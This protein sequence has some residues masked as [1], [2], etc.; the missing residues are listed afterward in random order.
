MKL[1]P[2]LRLGPFSSGAA[3]SL[4][5]MSG[6]LDP[7]ITFARASTATF[8]G[9]DGLIQSAAIDTPRF[10]YDPVT[11]AAKGLLIE[12]ARTNLL[13]Y[14]EQFDNAA[15]T[16]AEAT[17]S[18]NSSAAPDGTNT[19]DK[20]IPNVATLSGRVVQAFA[21]SIGATY[22]LSAYAKQAEFTNF[23]LYSDDGSANS[24]SVSYNLAT[25]AVTTAAAPTGTWT[26]VSAT[27][28]SVGNG[29][30][31]FT[32]TWTATSAAPTRVALWCRD[33]GDGTSGIFIWGA[34]LEAGSFATSYI[35]TVASQV[36][37]SADV[38]TMTG[39]NFSSWYN[40]TQGTFVV[41]A[42]T[43][44]P[45][46][47]AAVSEIISANDNTTNNRITTRFASSTVDGIVVVSGA[48]VA[49]ISTAYTAGA[50]T[51]IALGSAAND[52]A[53]AVAGS[54]IGTD[55]A[56]AMPAVTKLDIGN[57]TG[58]NFLNGHIRQITYYNTRLPN[59]TLQVLTA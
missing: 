52:F 7:R 33:T 1:Q 28:T 46:T 24:A 21:G 54:L 47:L 13:T 49:A 5:F 2:N 38:A 48:A 19:A 14:S 44:K 6:T 45:T 3:L 40:Q 57:L 20:L 22:T 58:F 41:S 27:A 26:S 32:L 31:R 15:W 59:A 4:D 39:T 43:A 42:D 17:V 51:K 9:S 23:R 36:T 34:Q 55:T 50:V 56:G 16:K 12:E 37:R 10:D 53:F 25:G 8:V 11:L 29:W 30:W 35:P 18:A